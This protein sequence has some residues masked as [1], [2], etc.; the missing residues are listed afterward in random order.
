MRQH[1]GSLIRLRKLADE[2]DVQDRVVAMNYLQ[3]REAVGEIV[4]GLLY[5]DPDPE[6][7]HQHLNTVETPFN[8][9][10][11]VALIPGAAAL[12]RLNASLR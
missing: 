2:Y 7:L 9:L 6:D 11:E 12:N 4:T 5:L 8:E 1:D 3:Q 10:D